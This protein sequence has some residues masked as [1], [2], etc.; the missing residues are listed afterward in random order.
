MSRVLPEAIITEKNKLAGS[1]AWVWLL[2]LRANDTQTYYFANNAVA[3]TF[4]GNSYKPFPFSIGDFEETGK[5]DPPRVPITVQNPSGQFSDIIE[6]NN[7]FTDGIC[8]LTLYNPAGATDDDREV[9]YGDFRIQ[10]VTV[11]AK[12]ASFEIGNDDL[13][14]FFFPRRR[15]FRS[16]CTHAY[17]GVLCA[18]A[19][20]FA[21]CDKTLT[22]A[23]GCLAHENQQRYGGYPGI[24][25]A[26]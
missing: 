16:K 4:R 22:G 15:F 13:Y 8:T 1:A 17:K 20:A 11:N 3:I 2:E 6:K 10:H 5:D 9:V 18:Y 24:L 12:V 23:N 21:T 26:L 19:G 7:G 14:R 25:R